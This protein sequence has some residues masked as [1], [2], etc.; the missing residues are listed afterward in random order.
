MNSFMPIKDAE[1]SFFSRIQSSSGKALKASTQWKQAAGADI[2]GV[3]KKKRSKHSQVA[4]EKSLN[5]CDRFHTTITV[6]APCVRIHAT[7]RLP[8]LLPK[9][10]IVDDC[11]ANVSSASFHPI[12]LRR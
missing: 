8:R 1:E 7:K 2:S 9:H 11:I 6:K 10:D 5:I 4:R 12:K 3:K